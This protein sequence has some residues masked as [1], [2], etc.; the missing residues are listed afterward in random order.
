MVVLCRCLMLIIS[1]IFI[2]IRREKLRAIMIHR[3]TFSFILFIR[4]TGEKWSLLLRINVL[5]QV[6]LFCLG[7]WCQWCTM[8]RIVLAIIHWIMNFSYFSLEICLKVLKTLR[9]YHLCFMIILSALCHLILIIVVL[10]LLIFNTW[11]HWKTC[12][13]RYSW[14]LNV[15]LVTKVHQI[16]FKLKIINLLQ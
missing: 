3:L 2:V 5:E 15:L 16:L 6:L 4:D 9:I 1:W 11:I 12:I 8:L 7:N 14:F 10:L 13:V